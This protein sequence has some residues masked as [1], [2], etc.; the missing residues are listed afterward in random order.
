M[1]K[2]ATCSM[3]WGDLAVSFM[4]S[5]TCQT[6]N[7]QK[8]FQQSKMISK[9]GGSIPEVILEFHYRFLEEIV[10]HRCHAKQKKNFDKI[11]KVKISRQISQKS[12]AQP[13]DYSR[14][15]IGQRIMV[16]VY[17]ITH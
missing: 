3:V 15:E 12:I 8:R 14:I 1:A 9:N 10:A 4:P 11:L 17:A 7:V 6:T 2:A 5:W 13:F 16:Q